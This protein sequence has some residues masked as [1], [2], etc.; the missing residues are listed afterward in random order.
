VQIAVVTLVMPVLVTMARTS[1]YAR[2]RIG[3]AAFAATAAIAWIIERLF[4][5]DNIVGR[6]I[7]AGLGHA[8][9]LLAGLVVL[10]GMMV[11]AERRVAPL[12]P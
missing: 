11:R 9:W 6:L 3:A 5:V 4:G 12:T 8:A 10:A 1:A 7:D 2:F